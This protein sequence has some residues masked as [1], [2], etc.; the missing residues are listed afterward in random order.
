MQFQW[1]KIKRL[2]EENTKIYDSSKEGAPS[3]TIKGDEKME[4]G[5]KNV[6]CLK[7]MEWRGKKCEL[8]N[9]V[10]DITVEGRIVA[11]DPREP[12]LDNDFGETEIGVTMLS[13]P[14]H[15]SQIMIIWRW[16]LSRTILDGHC[17]LSLLVAYDEHH[18]S[19]DEDEK[20][21]GVKKKSYIFLKRKQ[22]E[23]KH[24]AS[25]SRIDQLLS[26]ESICVMSLN[27]C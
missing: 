10:E 12:V 3:T 2:V 23:S 22:R 1:R 16:L 6:P 9:H 5:M 20:V 14:K 11:C 8:V 7:R 17:L 24:E 21:V 25:I 4:N 15:T 18:M 19:K 27:N 26:N 13:C